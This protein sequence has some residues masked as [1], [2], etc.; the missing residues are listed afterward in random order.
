MK[1][2]FFGT[3]EI[4][5]P[6]LHWLLD[7]PEVELLAVVT[8]PDRPVGRKLVLTPPE[9]KVVATARRIPVYQPEKIKHFLET[10]AKLDA[11]IYVV[12]AYGQILPKALLEQPKV[13]C[14][15]LHASLLPRHRGAAPIQAALLAGD[16]HSG[17]SVMHIDVGLDSGDVILTKAIMLAKDETGASLHDRLAL[18]APEALAQALPQLMAGTSARIPQDAAL[19]THQP[20]LTRENGYLDFRLPAEI[21]ERQIRAFYPWPGSGII[22]PSTHVLKVFPPVMVEP[23]HGVPGEVLLADQH[24][25][26]IACG[27]GALR[28]TDLQAEGKRRM[29]IG[30][31]LAGNDLPNRV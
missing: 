17:I 1:I 24:G 22:L 31:Y 8:Q 2:V 19:V 9:I 18:L 29:K 26:V 4:A 27:H 7:A 5:L 21:L 25:L 3:G 13:A 20:K 14:I 11:D 10:L 6:T 12:M 23:S 15:N 28:F 30:E 16:T